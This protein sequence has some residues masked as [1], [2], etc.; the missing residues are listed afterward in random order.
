MKSHCEV[1]RGHELGEDTIELRVL[2]FLSFSAAFG[3]FN[4]LPTVSSVYI[5]HLLLTSVIM[6]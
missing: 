6:P 2:I 5:L 4:T 3:A 1:P